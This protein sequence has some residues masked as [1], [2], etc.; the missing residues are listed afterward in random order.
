M[1]GSGEDSPGRYGEGTSNMGNFLSLQVTHVSLAENYAL[2]SPDRDWQDRLQALL[3]PASRQNNL[4]SYPTQ[5]PAPYALPSLRQISSPAPLPHHQQHHQQSQQQ[6]QQTHP[7]MQSSLPSVYSTKL[8]TSSPVP[9]TAMLAPINTSYGSHS[10]LSHSHSPQPGSYHPQSGVGANG[11]RLSWDGFNGYQRTGMG[12]GEGA[13]GPGSDDGEP[14]ARYELAPGDG[15]QLNG[16]ESAAAYQLPRVQENASSVPLPFFEDAG[17]DADLCR[18][19]LY[20]DTQR[21][22]YTNQQAVG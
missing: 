15:L 2:V 5:A 9:N 7:L 20:S 4:P 6:Q 11:A 14:K 1:A 22:Y 18:L 10:P 19:G 21:W 17:R 13:G 12:A 16:R 3:Q 8:E